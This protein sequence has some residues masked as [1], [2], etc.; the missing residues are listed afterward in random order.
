MLGCGESEQKML[1]LEPSQR[2]TARNAL[3]HEYFKDI[4]LIP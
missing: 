4:G 1:M 3:E 2:V